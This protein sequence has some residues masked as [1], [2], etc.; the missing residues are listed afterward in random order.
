MIRIV[1]IRR[2]NFKKIIYGKRLDDFLPMAMKSAQPEEN[3]LTHTAVSMQS[4]IKD[5]KVNYYSNSITMD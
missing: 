5:G 3:I 1:N 4:K 2:V